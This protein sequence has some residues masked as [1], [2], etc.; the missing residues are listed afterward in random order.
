MEEELELQT[1]AARNDGLARVQLGPLFCVRFDPRK[2][3]TPL[4]VCRYAV[5]LSFRE[6]GADT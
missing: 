2:T 4:V 3:W 6:K 1:L 5:Y